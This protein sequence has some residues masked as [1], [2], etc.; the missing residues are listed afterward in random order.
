MKDLGEAQAK[1]LRPLVDRVTA[2]LA[3]PDDQIEAAL[4]ALQRDLPRIN[5]EVLKD[6]SLR[7]AFEKILGTAL[8]QGAA[9]SSEKQSSSTK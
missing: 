5:R 3:L 7:Y 8:V 1:A 2:I 9:T 6:E 4:A